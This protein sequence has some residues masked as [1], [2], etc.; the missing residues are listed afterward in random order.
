VSVS[1]PPEP[2]DETKTI[3]LLVLL[4][5]GTCRELE[6]GGGGEGFEYSRC[7]LSPDVR[8]ISSRL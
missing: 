5:V 3:E 8:Y 6:G 2:A 4:Y 1:R 7:V